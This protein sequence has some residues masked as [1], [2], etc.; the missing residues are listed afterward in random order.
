LKRPDR[1]GV[2]NGGHYLRAIANDPGVGEQSRDV[3]IAVISDLVDVPVV[4]R[5]AEAIPLAQDRQPRK[6]GLE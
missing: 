4:E 6:S 2:G 1:A 5:N 3:P